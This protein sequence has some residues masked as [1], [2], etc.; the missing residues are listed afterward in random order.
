MSATGDARPTMRRTREA[1]A[2]LIEMLV[3]IGILGLVTALVFPAWSSP[4]R[5][6][7]LAEARAS[8][9]ANLRTAR[10]ASVRGG[11][12]VRLELTDDGR[13]Y[14]W[15]GARVSLPAPVSVDGD[16]RAITFYADGSSSGGL[17]TL[18]ERERAVRVAID[19]ATGLAR[20]G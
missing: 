3:V 16:P 10:A 2:T 6:V 14:G 1:G 9:I 20:P 18:S 8:L 12:A 15:S 11:E 17:L 5:G 4:L 7:Q 13:G 19:P